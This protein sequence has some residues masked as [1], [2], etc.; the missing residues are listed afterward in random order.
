MAKK[1]TL[2]GANAVRTILK[3]K[4]DFHADLR[5]QEED[6]G[7]TTYVFDIYYGD[8]NGTFTVATEGD[9][10]VIAVLNLSMGKI[11]SMMNDTNIRKL[12]QYVLDTAL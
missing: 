3:N 10:I 8:T 7:R 1:L 9:R 5:S 6:G 2:N 12:A 4:E 11:I